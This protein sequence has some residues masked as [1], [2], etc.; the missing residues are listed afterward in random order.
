MLIYNGY[1][2]FLAN[3]ARIKYV[4]VNQ[5]EPKITNFLNLFRYIIEI[6]IN[7]YYFKKMDAPVKIRLAKQLLSNITY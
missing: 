5:N 1:L 7:Y 2:N 3:M 4:A 6:F